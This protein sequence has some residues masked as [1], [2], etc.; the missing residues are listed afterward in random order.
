MGPCMIAHNMQQGHSMEL[1]DKRIVEEK[2][3]NFYNHD[4]IL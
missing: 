1:L 2:I 3:F 4:I